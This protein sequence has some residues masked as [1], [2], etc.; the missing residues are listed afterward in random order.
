MS[1]V[2]IKINGQAYQV[3]AGMT[4]LPIFM[5]MLMPLVRL[6]SPVICRLSWGQ[7]VQA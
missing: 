2:N 3:E 5:T 4:V 6:I 7:M 1:L